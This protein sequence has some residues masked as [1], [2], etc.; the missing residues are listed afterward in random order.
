MNIVITGSA[1]V[2]KSTIIRCLMALGH[3]HLF[4]QDV[5]VSE[6]YEFN[7]TVQKQLKFAFGVSTKA[8]V[9]QVL[10]DQP[11]QLAKN[12][13]HLF[14]IFGPK[15]Q[16]RLY[17]AVALAEKEQKHLLIDFP[18]YFEAQDICPEFLP[19]K[20]E[21]VI[22]L[23]LEDSIRRER[24]RTRGVPADRIAL[25]E[26][27]QYSQEYKALQTDQAVTIKLDETQASTGI[28]YHIANFISQIEE[29]SIQ[30]E[31]LLDS[32]FNYNRLGPYYF[33]DNR[34]Y[35]N[36]NTHILPMLIEL[37]KAVSKYSITVYSRH[38]LVYAILFHDLVYDV[39][40]KTS[41]EQS[42]DLFLKYI[43]RPTSIYKVPRSAMP[44]FR[45]LVAAHILSTK[46]HVTPNSFPLS[47]PEYASDNALLLDL[48][49]FILA[50]DDI[51]TYEA[52]IRQEYSCYSDEEYFNGRSQFLSQLIGTKV[53]KTEYFK[54]Y[55]DIAQGNLRI[56][57]ASIKLKYKF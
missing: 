19:F 34:S 24:L 46:S 23:S 40:S 37:Y 1:G 50:S 43:P 51:L 26:S 29:I 25:F 32:G 8:E 35:H 12:I 41:E 31:K 45:S 27:M 38:A 7:K 52:Q 5:E 54:K 21:L 6:M 4:E 16:Q 20:V 44:V 22:N 53:F 56:L 3:Y 49:M 55:E 36:L 57:L 13:R 18:M 47:L 28:A 10:I 11:D 15:V 30:V 39:K 17:K 48:D 42:A 9:S 2:G 33:E 14:R